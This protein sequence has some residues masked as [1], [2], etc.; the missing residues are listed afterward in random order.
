[1]TISSRTPEGLPHRCPICGQAT[2]LDPSF[3]GG[4]SVCPNCGH[5]LWWVRDRIALF[6]GLSPDE[7]VLDSM[8]MADLNGDSLDHLELIQEFEEEF[9]VTIPIEDARQIRTVADMIRFLLDQ[10]GEAA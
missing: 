3:P 1:M 6:A 7:I 9:R 5:L 4:D 2:A 10:R 8:L